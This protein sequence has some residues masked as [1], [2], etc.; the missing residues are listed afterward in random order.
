MANFL[1]RLFGDE[2]KSSF[3]HKN[4]ESVDAENKEYTLP[5]LSLLCR[6]ASGKKLKS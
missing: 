2:Q 5:Q 3:E 1:R 4:Q 6:T